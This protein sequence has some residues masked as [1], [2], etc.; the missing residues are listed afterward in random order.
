MLVIAGR[1]AEYFLSP[2][3]ALDESIHQQT[4]GE[5]SGQQTWERLA[6]LVALRLWM[7]AWADKKCE[8]RVRSDNMSALSMGSRMKIKASPLIAKEMALL[9]SHAAHEPR[10]F[11]HLP[12]VANVLADGLSRVFEPGAD[13]KLPPQLSGT[14]RRSVPKRGKTWYQ[15]LATM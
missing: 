15:T 13:K 14:T 1:I 11:E 3:T 6:V 7:S 5:S 9:Y 10:I 2:L 4:I 12:G 8:V